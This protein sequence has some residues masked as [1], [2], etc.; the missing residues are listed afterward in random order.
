MAG[1][2]VS[3]LHVTLVSSSVEASGI[4]RYV[5]QLRAGLTASA[6]ATTTASFQYL[7]GSNRRSILKALPVGIEGP[8]NGV[9]HLTQSYGAMVLLFRRVRPVVVTVHD[10]GALYCPEDQ[11]A[12]T[13]LSRY[14]F[15]ASLRGM[16]RA[17][18]IVAVS[19]FTR[20]HVI[21]AGFPAERVTTVHLGVETERFRPNPAAV[22][23]L[24]ERYGID[25]TPGCP[26]VLYVG[27]EFRRKNLGML[28]RALGSLKRDGVPF[29][30][31]K[32][33]AAGSPAARGSLL[34]RIDEAGIGDDVKIVDHVP[35]V[36]LPLFYAAATVYAQPSVWEGFGLPVAEAMASG[37]PVVVSR[38]GALPEVCGNA[39]YQVDPVDAGEMAVAI[40]QILGDPELRER[41]RRYGL[42]RASELSW[43]ATA[44]K[45]KAVYETL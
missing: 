16:R 10:L 30:W 45:T 22:D 42:R 35:D 29:R 4:G 19:E 27:N 20:Q 28:T 39:G 41:L 21:R 40:G 14:L 13:P 1:S 23:L 38:A 6:V 25:A 17:D 43:A 3:G 9:T 2:G 33:G 18:R 26:I 31:I 44:A 36:D 8:S 32:V 34:R 5:S 7:P 24:A 37:T 15:R 12:I 11:A